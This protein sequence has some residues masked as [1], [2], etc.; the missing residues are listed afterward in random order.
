MNKKMEWEDLGFD[1]KKDGY[2][3]TA[4][5]IKKR[6]SERDKERKKNLLALSSLGLFVF[7]VLS[8]IIW[9]MI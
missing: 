6:I 5:M 4:E 3:A 9:V 7:A 1:P 8:L 2:W